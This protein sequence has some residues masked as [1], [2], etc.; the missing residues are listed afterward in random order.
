MNSPLRTYIRQTFLVAQH[1]LSQGHVVLGSLEQS[2]KDRRKHQCAVK[3][4]SWGYYKNQNRGRP[5]LSTPLPSP[6]DTVPPFAEDPKI[7]TLEETPLSSDDKSHHIVDGGG[8]PI[9]QS[10]DKDIESPVSDSTGLT[11]EQDLYLDDTSGLKLP[12]Q[13]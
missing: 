9:E 1:L 5:H 11:E 3:F 8:S 6:A 10:S 13:S 12:E 7:S 4:A 2:N